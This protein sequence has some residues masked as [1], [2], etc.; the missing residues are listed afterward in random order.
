MLKEIIRKFTAT[1]VTPRVRIDNTEL[2]ASTGLRVVH[3]N[4][5]VTVA[6]RVLGSRTMEIATAVCH[7]KDV[8]SRRVGTKQ[9]VEN[10]QAGKKIIVPMAI[11]FADWDQA[12]YLGPVSTIKEMFYNV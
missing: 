6:Y 2:L 7:E 10:F 9:A 8:F 1:P 3:V 4:N 5:R 12:Y 11:D